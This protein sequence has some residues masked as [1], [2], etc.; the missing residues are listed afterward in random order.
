[1]DYLINMIKIK[2]L[3]IEGV[4]LLEIPLYND[5]RGS[6]IESLNNSSQFV[7]KIQESK[8]KPFGLINKFN[9]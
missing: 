8:N 1:M 9:K 3:E 2:N 4:L 7:R 5:N 6:F